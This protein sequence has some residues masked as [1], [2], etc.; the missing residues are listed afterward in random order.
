MILCRGM[1]RYNSFFF[2]LWLFHV[3]HLCNLFTACDCFTLRF[4]GYAFF[5]SIWG[6]FRFA[7]FLGFF[8]FFNWPFNKRGP[9]IS[10]CCL[11]H[12]AVAHFRCITIYLFLFY[13]FRIWHYKKKN[14]LA[15]G[16]AMV[17]IPNSLQWCP[18]ATRGHSFTRF[19]AGTSQS[20]TQ[21]V[22]G[23]IRGPDTSV[24][25]GCAAHTPW[26]LQRLSARFNSSLF[27]NHG[28]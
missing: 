16:V 7:V 26:V 5:V 17:T 24:C 18:T 28:G 1:Q 25:W 6:H 11:S 2:C 4:V 19:Q 20:I 12:R 14:T 21:V 10:S 15:V 9:W 8:C 3:W 13:L 27:G 23:Q 22:K